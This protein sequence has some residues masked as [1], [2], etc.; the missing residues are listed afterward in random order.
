MYQY[1]IS[2]IFKQALQDNKAIKS[3]LPKGVSVIGRGVKIQKFEDKTEI[4]NMNKGGMY[5]KECTNEEYKLFFN[6]GWV[7]GS[8]YLSLSNCL[9]KLKN[10]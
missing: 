7:L 8:K 6:H 10:N 5:Y 2:D 3:I 9:H 1:D 4:L